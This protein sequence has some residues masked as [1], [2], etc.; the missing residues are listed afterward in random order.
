MLDVRADEQGIVHVELS[1]PSMARDL[2]QLR[3]QLA[4]CLV[5]DRSGVTVD[6]SAIDRISSPTVAA[7][8][9]A[10]RTCAARHL[11]FTVTGYAQDSAVLRSC[12]LVDTHDWKP[13]SW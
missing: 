10:R 1:E 5:R 6:L 11:P 4:E 3:S 7:L 8:L 13:A 9:W 12:G 2:A